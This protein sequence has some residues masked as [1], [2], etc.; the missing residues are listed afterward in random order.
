M[1]MVQVMNALKAQS[2]SRLVGPNCP[3]IIN[4]AGCKI[5]IMPGHIHRPGK[6]GRYFSFFVGTSH[7]NM[8]HLDAQH[9]V[10]LAL[11]EVVVDARPLLEVVPSPQLSHSPSTYQ[12]AL[13][14]KTP[15]RTRICPVTLVGLPSEAYLDALH[16]APPLHSYIEW[17]RGSC[18][19]MAK[20]R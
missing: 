18:S 7:V 8:G 13:A 10:H 17:C 20:S 4:P 16:P 19:H 5:G 1:C 9:P 2:K 12:T 15:S 11:K 6:I 14:L 3:G